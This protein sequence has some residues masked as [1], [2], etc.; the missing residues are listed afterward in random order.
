MLYYVRVDN[1]VVMVATDAK[2]VAAFLAASEVD[3]DLKDKKV[4]VEERK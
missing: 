4:E 3:P 2:D 1:E